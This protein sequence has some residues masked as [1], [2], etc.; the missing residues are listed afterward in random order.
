[1]TNHSESRPPA[2]P[3]SDAAA[4]TVE[5]R[6]EGLR[7]SASGAWRT[8]TLGPV[9]DSLQSLEIG[10]VTVATIDLSGLSGLDTNGAWLI[11]RQLRRLRAAGAAT[12][13]TGADA[14]QAALLEAVALAAIESYETSPVP[15]SL[16][17]TIERTGRATC[18]VLREGRDLLNFLGALSLALG[19]A[20]LRPRRIR[21]RAVI[22]QMERTGLN[23]L[24]IVGL[25]S[26]LIG[27]VLAYQGADQL[28]QFGAQIYTVNLVGIGV[29][30]EMGVL[31]TAIIVAGRSGSAFTAQIGTMK[32][33]QEVDALSTLGLSPM[34]VLVIPRVL[35][36]LLV[37]PLLVFYANLMG[38]LGGAVMATLAL[39]ISFA[40][41]VRQFH[42]AVPVSAFFVGL[43]KAPLF[44]FV[45]GMVGCYE[46]L[47]VSGSAE[48]VGRLTTRAVV[49]SVF[50][51]I[52]LDAFL[53]IFFS[54]IGV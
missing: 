21:M 6:G 10:G 31:I 39:D 23:A 49:E 16:T 3:S 11:E 36:L 37:M 13:C 50:L 29:L 20:I 42:A 46:G 28:S 32:V 45:I 35:G 1:M 48:S 22:A 34:D 12:E 4:V 41:F 17:A 30:R 38:I 5:R 27:V 52:V 2:P 24:P 51:V 8:E 25:L 14:R 43:V 18:E 33:N 47:K 19:G 54:V 9:A 26:F 53:S 40:Q 44:A 15:G 7:L